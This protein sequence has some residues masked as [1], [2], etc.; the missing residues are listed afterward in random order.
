MS[1]DGRALRWEQHKAERRT[2]I[3]DAAVTVIEREP[4]GTVLHVQQ[5][6][7]EAGLSRPVVYRHFADRADLDDAIQ[8]H[9]LGLVTSEVLPAV[10]LSGT[11]M[12]VIEGIVSSYVRWA[13]AHPKLHRIAE[14]RAS[15]LDSALT[16]VGIGISSLIATGADLYGVTLTDEERA[17][18]PAL[19]AGLIGWVLG[20]VHVWMLRPARE[21]SAE[22]MSDLLS[23]S[24]WYLLQGHARNHGLELD[25]DAPLPL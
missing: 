17:A 18:L 7:E 8:R 14:E 10:V 12:G 1:T 25:P 5:I 6:A 2:A 16:S 15:A 11:I 3:L 9:V 20:S 22:A 24:I 4:V 23:R 19:T 13:H 21:P